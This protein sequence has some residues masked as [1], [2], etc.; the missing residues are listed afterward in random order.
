MVVSKHE[1]L[2]LQV[3]CIITKY[4]ALAVFILLVQHTILHS[5]HKGN[6]G[7][8]AM[9]FIFM[10]T[11]GDKTVGNCVEILEQ[12]I[13]SG[14]THIGFKDIGVDSETLAALSAAIKAGGAI[15]YMEVV[16]TT[17]DAVYDSITMAAEIG[18]DRVL[19]GQDIEFALNA[20]NGTGA[21]YYPFPGLP[22]GHP[23]ILGGSPAKIEA[24][25]ARMR[26]SIKPGPMSVKNSWR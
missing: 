21:S 8:S 4:V 3:T 25:C 26:V 23:T 7:S 18:I 6:S 9:D 22:V 15:S 19:G 10:L 17:P 14:V 24:D 13:D 12:G 2:E 11:H 16:S 20:L 5:K 1:H